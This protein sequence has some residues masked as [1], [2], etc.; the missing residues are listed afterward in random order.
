[1]CDYYG[2]TR[3]VIVHVKSDLIFNSL[4]SLVIGTET[5]DRQRG[6]VIYFDFSIGGS[7]PLLD[8]I[9]VSNSLFRVYCQS[10]VTDRFRW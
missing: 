9:R 1:M 10:M 3:H 2:G 5:D 4:T 7:N 6:V 8:Y